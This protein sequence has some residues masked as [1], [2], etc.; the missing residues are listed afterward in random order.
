MIAPVRETLDD[1]DTQ[2]AQRRAMLARLEALAAQEPAVQAASR[3]APS[4]GGEYLS[5]SNEGVVGADLQTR[6]KGAIEAAGAR[7]RAA[8]TLP[9]QTVERIRY[10]GAR[11]EIYG[12]L[13]A[14]HRAIAA[15]ESGKPY[16]FVQ[17]AV[18]K[19]APA[20][21]RPDIAQEPVIDGQIDVFG[22]LRNPASDR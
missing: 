22:A 3:Q 6:L 16:L 19:Q 17:A 21:G 11:M 10:I 2:I 5:G 9:A 7:L 20:A 18:I 14:V 13:P 4:D 1:R 15:I 8:R 12:S